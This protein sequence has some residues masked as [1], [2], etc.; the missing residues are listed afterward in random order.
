[1]IAA[2]L[3]SIRAANKVSSVQTYF[4]V[5][6][7]LGHIGLWIG[8]AVTYRVSPLKRR[9]P[10]PGESCESRF[11]V[12][13]EGGEPSNMDRLLTDHPRPGRTDMTF[14]D[15]HAVRW[16][17]RFNQTSRELW[18]LTKCATEE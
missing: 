18:I 15:G 6:V 14:G 10:L 8:V 3:I 9:I 1:M 17:R 2:Y 16:L 12:G 11:L 5:A 13:F 4:A 7:E